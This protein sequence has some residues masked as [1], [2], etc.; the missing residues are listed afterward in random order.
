MAAAVRAIGGRRRDGQEQMAV[1]VA[2][3]LGSGEHL[4]V[5]A[6]TGTGKSLAYLVPA[7]VHAVTT[8]ETVVVSTAT[9]ALQ[10]QV[11][12]RDLPAVAAALAPLLPRPV[13]FATLKG[14]RNYLCVHRVDGGLPADDDDAALFAAAPP[15]GLGREVLRLRQWAEATDTGD[16]DALDPG[17]SER[18]W[19]QVSVSSRE[20]LGA[21]RCP[22]ADR[23]FAEAARERARGA[24]VV[25][26]NHALLAIDAVEGLPVLP[27][28]ALV[29]V[30]EAHELVDR[31]TSVATGELSAG[32]VER[33]ARRAARIVHDD[34]AG[35]IEAL[36]GAGVS[37]RAVLD[38][39][40]EGRLDAS[41]EPLT[42]S[43]AA[44]RDAA[45]TV[46]TAITAERGADDG[47][48]TLARAA[49]D[50]VHE[51][52]ERLAAGS[53][54]DVVWVHRDERRGPML[55]VAPLSVQGLLR[56]TLFEQAT[57]VLTS[58]TLS[59]GGSFDLVARGLGLGDRS[60]DEAAAGELADAPT[61]DSP[62]P[63][64][65]GLARWRGLDVGS[66]IDY[67]RQGI[68]YV[69]RHLPR[70]GRDGI[71]AAALD[72]LAELVTAAGGRTLGLFSSMRAA[73]AAAAAMR[74]RLDV[75]VLCQGED[76]TAALVRAFAADGPT[77]LF[78]TLSLWQGV[79]VPGSACQLV[80]IDRIPFPR[81]DDP[82]ASA[83]ARA[84]EAAG[85]NGFMTVS[86]AHAALRLAQGMGRL[87][88]SGEDRGVVAV[89][90]PRLAT[91]RYAG[92]LRAS[93][94]GFWATTDSAQVRRSLAA[95]AALAASAPPPRAVPDV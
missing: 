81:P 64:A 86:A 21:S 78:G 44:L 83:R 52:A 24:D 88:R 6:G 25:V 35:P 39:L 68:L 12:D 13:R 77:C 92:F 91:A 85:G 46:L 53:E 51:V 84:V 15:S 42:V 20:C 36:A 23:C 58:A 50:A 26:T 94:P 66:P 82:L 89:L 4:L 54:H 27:E 34:G 33:A 29:V 19:G 8:G 16:R 43:L 5:Q 14:R 32:M 72:E 80:V 56:T 90:D 70:P 59:L 62:R 22:A 93:L 38:A 7:V 61:P 71:A 60:A 87:I 40:P 73:T 47:A 11:A 37:L 76:R 1:A 30:D 31:V 18:A 79:D 48:K 3:A 63:D 57:V 95:L 65:P 41:P 55:Y 67:P 9:I 49:V 75:P 28:H 45:R 69:A 74:E 10:Q 2:E 17:V